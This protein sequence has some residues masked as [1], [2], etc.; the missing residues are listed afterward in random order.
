MWCRPE[1]SSV[2]PIYMPGR[3]RTASRPRSTLIDCALYSSS[4]ACGIAGSLM[5]FPCL[6]SDSAGRDGGGVDREELSMALEF[7]EELRVGAGKPALG[8]EVAQD[9]EERAPPCRIEMR[10]DF[11]E[12]QHGSGAPP[13]RDKPRI[14]EDDGDQQGLLLAGRA[15]R[16][17]LVLAKM[18]RHK[19]GAVRA[20]LRRAAVAVESARIQQAAAEFFF[21]GERRHRPERSLDRAFHREARARERA[22]GFAAGGVE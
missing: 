17:R 20:D 12:Q 13:R 1:P 14:G 21:G 11:I 6:T 18:A 7:R 19:I 9:A 2:S 4:G 8:A 16:R 5:G 15:M 3:L 10:G 22:G